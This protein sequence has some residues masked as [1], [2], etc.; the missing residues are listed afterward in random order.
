MN[1]SNKTLLQIL[2]EE[3]PKN[4][5][6]LRD[7]KTMT[8]DRSG[9]IWGY[10]CAS[11]YLGRGNFWSSKSGEDL[12]RNSKIEVRDVAVDWNTAIITREQYEA[13]LAD[14]NDGWIEWGGGDCP[15]PCGTLVDVRYR[16]GRQLNTLSANNGTLNPRDASFVFWRNDGNEK[17]II[18]YRLHRPQEVAQDKADSEADLNECIGQTPAQVWNGE[19]LPPVGVE[20]EYGSHRS[21]AKCLAHGLNHVFA[22]KGD[23][24]SEDGDYE[25]FL[26][27]AGTE[28]YPVDEDRAAIRKVIK[29]AG[30]T[31]SYADKIAN[32][33]ID[34]GYRKQ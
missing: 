7:V 25:E 33:L 31:S 29:A 4:G 11:P 5:G 10:D 9:D 12:V 6:W 22:S 17:D 8:Q 2:V 26:I 28:Y 18:A 34:A 16:D 3:L 19:G 30:I 27:D 13:A 20:F 21:R 14:K 24:N 15:V 23:P 1:T 32:V